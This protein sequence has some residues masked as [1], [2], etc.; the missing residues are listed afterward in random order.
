ME[1]IKVHMTPE[2]V[3][4]SVA[5]QFMYS[6]PYDETFLQNFANIVELKDKNETQEILINDIRTII[7]TLQ[8]IKND[9]QIKYWILNKDINIATAF[10]EMVIN[11]KDYDRLYDMYS[12][13]KLNKT[14]L[15]QYIDFKVSDNFKYSELRREFKNGQLVL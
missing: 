7:V 3:S 4:L 13:F 14:Y 2:R 10:A 11:K 12:L 8:E 9:L 15:A 1:K 5:G 6:L